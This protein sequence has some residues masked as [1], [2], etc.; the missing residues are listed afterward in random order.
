MYASLFIFRWKD[1][2][3][4]LRRYPCKETDSGTPPFCSRRP[5]MEIRTDQWKTNRKSIILQK[6]QAEIFLNQTLHW[7]EGLFRSQT[8]DSV[9]FPPIIATL[10]SGFIIW[11]RSMRAWTRPV[12]PSNAHIWFCEP[13]ETTQ[14]LSK[15][16]TC[17][18]HPK[19][20]THDLTTQSPENRDIGA[21]FVNTN[22]ITTLKIAIFL[23][24]Y[25]KSHV[26]V[27]GIL[28][29]QIEY[30]TVINRDLLESFIQIRGLI[31]LSADSASCRR[32]GFCP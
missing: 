15:I 26:F 14:H 9:Q 28:D 32:F 30:S 16:W 12:D 5:G 10:L 25:Y 19:R 2:E 17:L 21:A 29:S 22:L 27:L 23:S 31:L 1:N 7:I 3:S 11:S 18:Q 6:W 20:E 13:K 4:K 24:Q 8:V